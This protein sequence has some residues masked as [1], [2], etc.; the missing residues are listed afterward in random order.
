MAPRE[1]FVSD[2]KTS[3]L[4]LKY[5]YGQKGYFTGFT[6]YFETKDYI[7]LNYTHKDLYESA[8]FA[9]KKKKKG[10]LG[11]FLLSLL[12]ISPLQLTV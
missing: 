1:K 12:D 8:Y 6:G 9:N 7:L 3:L 4:A 10:A 11:S 2:P 5:E